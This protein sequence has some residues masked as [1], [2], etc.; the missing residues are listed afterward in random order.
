MWIFLRE[1]F[2]SVVVDRERPL[3]LLVRARREG[4]IE[5][6]LS[7]HE[8][9]LQVVQ[10]DHAD[11]RFRASVSRPVFERAMKAQVAAV[12]YTNFKDSVDAEDGYRHDVYFGVWRAALPLDERRSFVRDSRQEDL[13]ED[14]PEESDSRIKDAVRGYVSRK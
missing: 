7:G 6:L 11:Y 4:D 13:F 1:S 3:H 5:N 8:P 9:G 12:D 2:V 14:D 10:T